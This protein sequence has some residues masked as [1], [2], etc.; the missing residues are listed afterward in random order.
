VDAEVDLVGLDALVDDFDSLGTI[1]HF[2]KAGVRV[3][4]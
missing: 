4:Q 1:F 3:F 2:L